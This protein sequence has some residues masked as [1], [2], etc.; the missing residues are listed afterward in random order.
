[1]A[2][3]FQVYHSL[4]RHTSQPCCSTGTEAEGKVTW[5]G[6]LASCEPIQFTADGSHH[7]S[8]R[9]HACARH[10]RASIVWSHHI[11]LQWLPT[12]SGDH[13]QPPGR[14]MH[15]CAD[16]QLTLTATRW[17]LKTPAHTFPKHPEPRRTSRVS[18]G[19]GISCMPLLVRCMAC[20]LADATSQ[21]VAHQ[22]VAF[23]EASHWNASIEDGR[24]MRG[25]DWCRSLLVRV[26]RCICMGC[27]YGTWREV[28]VFLLHHQSGVTRWVGVADCSAERVL[29]HDGPASAQEAHAESCPSMQA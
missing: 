3:T 13:G 5:L 19:N 27:W 9:S 16:W 10:S 22:K 24:L 25:E 15:P 14:L 21:N 7:H 8:L 18:S 23:G 1:M 4:L 28:C 2:I 12:G 29:A 6:R 11:R 20:E 26:I 17:P